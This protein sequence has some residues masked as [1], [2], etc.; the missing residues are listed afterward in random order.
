MAATLTAG[1]GQDLPPTWISLTLTV[2]AIL[3]TL[4]NKYENNRHL[5][6]SVKKIVDF[7]MNLFIKINVLVLFLLL[8]ILL[9]IS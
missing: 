8:K 1:A 5:F 9:N 4:K 7:I 3:L 2:T 6:S